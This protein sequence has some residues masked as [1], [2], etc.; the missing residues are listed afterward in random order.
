V[1]NELDGTVTVL[2]GTGNGTF[3]TVPKAPS[4]GSY[5]VQ[6]AVGDFNGDGIPDLAAA[7]FFGNKITVLLGK[8][9]G[10]FTVDPLS[11]TTGQEPCCVAVADFNG[12]G[13]SDLAAA[14]QYD[15]PPSV[16]PINVFLSEL[17]ETT[18]A[19]V[20]HVAPPG[21]GTHNVN[22]SYPGDSNYG[23]SIS[24]VVPLTG[25]LI[26][27][28]LSLTANPK[29]STHGESVSLTAKLSPYDSEAYTTDGE[30]VTFYNGSTV[31]GK[32]ALSLGVATLKVS[33]LAVGTHTLKASYPGD[34]RF[35]AASTSLKFVVK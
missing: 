2:L 9:D 18:T 8:G 5:P 32:S 20:T 26:P 27:T 34:P 19:T 1:P 33:S 13:L 3:K 28:T 23:P 35:K 14:L 17:T 24:R 29:T 6:I 7:N 12:D 16:D 21:D 31:L 15:S 22:A 11:P 30:I 25:V 10:T 4:A